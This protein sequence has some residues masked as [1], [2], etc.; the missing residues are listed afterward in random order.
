MRSEESVESMFF[1]LCIL[2]SLVVQIT[3]SSK[4][5]NFLT[6]KTTSS[7]VVSV[8][9]HFPCLHLV[10]LGQTLAADGCLMEQVV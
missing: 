7:A 8:K 9:V 10:A 2:P 4:W 5:S 3:S 6:S 1:Q